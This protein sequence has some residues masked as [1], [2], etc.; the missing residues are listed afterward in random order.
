[1]FTSES[2]A[3]S[4]ERREDKDWKTVKL[5]DSSWL[6]DE[7]LAIPY[8]LPC[9]RYR[10]LTS[11]HSRRCDDIHIPRTHLECPAFITWFEDA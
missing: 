9:V 4:N 5:K 7:C 2:V 6:D 11:G 1:M 10:N 3:S 8:I